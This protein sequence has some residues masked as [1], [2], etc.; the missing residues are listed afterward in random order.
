MEDKVLR[1]LAV[2][3][4]RGLAVVREDFIWPAGM[5]EPPVRRR[6]D[7]ESVRDIELICPEEIARAAHLVLEAQF[8]MAAGDLAGQT[9]KLLG[10]QYAGA[11]IAQRVDAVVRDEVAAGRI[12]QEGD[13]LRMPEQLDPD[14]GEQ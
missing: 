14:E 13:Q 1:A 5:A 12:V 2:A 10:F 3:A 8:G 11:K 4:E 9:A 6:A 7:S